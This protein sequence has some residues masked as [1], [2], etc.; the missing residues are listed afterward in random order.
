MLGY[1]MGTLP[2]VGKEEGGS[3]SGKRKRECFNAK[4]QFAG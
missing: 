4:A 2:V 1:I 3:Y